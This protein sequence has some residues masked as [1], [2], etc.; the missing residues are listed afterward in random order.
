MTRRSFL[1]ALG[2]TA[3]PP[4]AAAE[5]VTTASVPSAIEYRDLILARFEARSRSQKQQK[6]EA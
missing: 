2:L 4:A 6:R 1:A 5:P 3:V